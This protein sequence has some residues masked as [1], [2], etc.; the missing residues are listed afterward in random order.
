MLVWTGKKAIVHDRVQ[1]S[2]TMLRSNRAQEAGSDAQQA[3]IDL[4]QANLLDEFCR[5]CDSGF[6]FEEPP[7]ALGLMDS[8]Y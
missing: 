2:Y 8:I 3:G 4:G 5:I 6:G 7:L 1:C